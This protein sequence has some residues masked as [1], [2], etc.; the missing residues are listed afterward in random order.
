MG[1]A[2]KNA[3]L[4]DEYSRMIGKCPVLTREQEYE[5][6]K[7][8][9]TD[10]LV[11]SQLPWVMRIAITVCR[12][13]KYH[14]I[15]LAISAGNAAL[16][17]SVKSFDGDRGFRLTTYVYRLVN[18]KVRDEIELAKAGCNP[19]KG[20][21][22]RNNVRVV[23]R[24]DIQELPIRDESEAMSRTHQRERT[25]KRVQSAVRRLPPH[26]RIAV[27]GRLRGLHYSQIAQDEGVTKQAIQQRVKSAMV[28]LTASLGK[29][30]IR[31]EFLS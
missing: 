29:E 31:E 11:R 12:R 15:D 6:W 7:R 26:L 3:C 28:L 2:P 22:K 5:A 23:L 19:S 14:D 27:Q 30:H 1:R 25:I 16:M 17:E 13:M 8:G 20:V 10:L 9:D 21:R 18:W 24:S 4:E